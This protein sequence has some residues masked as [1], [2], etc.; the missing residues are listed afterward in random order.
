MACP[1]MI[2]ISIVTP[3]SAKLEAI[4]YLL[5]KL[6]M[7]WLISAITIQVIKCPSKWSEILAPK[8]E[9]MI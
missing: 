8:A 7:I 5:N 4:S 3:K 2:I 1:T 6:Q 9:V